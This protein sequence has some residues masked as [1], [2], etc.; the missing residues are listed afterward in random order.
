MLSHGYRS[1]YLQRPTTHT[2]D[3]SGDKKKDGCAVFFRSSLFDLEQVDTVNF[4]DVHDRV[5]LLASA[6]APLPALF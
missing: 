3:W 5:A 2:S 6:I 1:V 4:R